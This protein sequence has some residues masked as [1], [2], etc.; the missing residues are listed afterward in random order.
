M[1]QEAS[2]TMPMDKKLKSIVV[3]HAGIV[4][5]G[6]TAAW[7]YKNLEARV[8]EIDRIVLLGPLHKYHLSWIATTSC[9]QWETPLGNITIDTDVI[10]Y[11]K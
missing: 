5:S 10:D 1:L 6:P 3:P 4:Q 2:V 7:G 8:T 11:L 9:N